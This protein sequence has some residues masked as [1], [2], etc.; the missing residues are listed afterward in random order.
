MEQAVEVV[1]WKEYMPP[2]CL[3]VSQVPQTR[4]VVR[5]AEAVSHDLVAQDERRVAVRPLDLDE[6]AEL[7]E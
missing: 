4:I 1:E 2:T 3:R 7:L 6:A 5:E